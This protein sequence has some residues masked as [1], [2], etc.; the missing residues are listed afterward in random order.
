MRLMAVR[1]AFFA[2]AQALV[3][4]EAMLFIDDD[5]RERREFDAFL[6]QG[7]RADDDGGMSG[8]DAL[9]ARRSRALPV[10]RPGQQ[11][12]RDSQGLEPAP[13]ILRMLIGQQFRRRHQ[14]HL[15]A[16]LHGLGRGQGRNQGLAAPHIPLHQ[17]QHGFAQPKVA[18][19]LEQRPLLRLGQAKR[20]CGQQLRLE[21]A[22]RRQR[23]AG[24]ALD[25][26]PQQLERQLMREQ[27][28]E[29]Q[30]ALRRMPPAQQQIHGSVG[31]RAM[32]I[33][34]GIAQRR[35]PRIGQDGCGQP[36]LDVAGT[37]LIERHAHQHAQASLR[38]A[39]GQ[40]IG[41]REMILGR[42]RGIRDRCADIPGARFQGPEDRG[43]LRRSSEC[44][45]RARDRSAAAR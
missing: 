21:G 16:G 44:A 18:L 25:A 8:A 36:I 9:R 19:D 1:G 37:G 26:L 5:Q 2:Q 4:A 23:P 38:H 12:H 20:Q 41:R 35:Q 28:L 31:G 30:S 29:G 14:R 3:H 34:Q 27:L 40:R 24:I 43:A 33:E 32:H 15:P 42:R 7:M 45:R 6:K 39:F 13:K 11:R 10:C 22:V 17:A